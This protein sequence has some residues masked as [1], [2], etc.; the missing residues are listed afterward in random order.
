MMAHM[1]IKVQRGVAAVEFGLL[2]VPLVLLAFGITEYGRAMYQYNALAK[3]ARS[4]VRYL[5]QQTPGDAAKIGT[6]KCLAVYGNDGCSGS[7]LVPGLTTSFVSVCDST[8]CAGSHRNQSTG[9]GSVDLV[10]VTVSG[11]AFTSLVPSLIPSITFGD[12]SAT[13]RQ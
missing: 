13:M 10:T 7:P 4:A 6:A 11:V 3:G 5:S 8:S 9:S 12:I 2:L 1:L